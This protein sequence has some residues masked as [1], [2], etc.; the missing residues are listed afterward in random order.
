MRYA[1]I[2]Y[3]SNP[4]TLNL[5]GSLGLGLS[6]RMR[7]ATKLA[8]QHGGEAPAALVSVG[9][10]PG[11]SL[12]H[13]SQT[14]SLSHPGTVR[15]VDKLEKAGLLERRPGPDGRT[16]ALHL[17]NAGKKRRLE[18]L[19]ERNHALQPIL[20][21][22]SEPEQIQLEY[23]LGKML[24]ALTTSALESFTLCRL[25]YEEVCPADQCPVE[26]RARVLA[27]SQDGW[28]VEGG[29]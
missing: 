19:T 17:T 4:R 15:L 27:E 22:L 25:C 9:I 1:Y 10:D 13:L 6:D 7:Q 28:R 23:L 12:Q 26:C 2:E 3:M 8:T 5:L 14:L 11:I 21:N 29:A 18:L 20:H 16:V 24:T